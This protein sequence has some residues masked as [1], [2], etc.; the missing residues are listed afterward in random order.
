[1]RPG[2]AAEGRGAP[3]AGPWAWVT[4]LPQGKA[5]GRLERSA[6]PHSAAARRRGSGRPSGQATAGRGGREKGRTEPVYVAVK[7]GGKAKAVK[8]FQK[9][10]LAFPSHPALTWVAPGR[11]G[12]GLGVGRLRP[13]GAFT[14]VG[15]APELF[16]G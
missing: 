14:A 9:R 11:A 7:Y 16:A 13:E 8:T 5:A 15:M 4:P 10:S 3:G 12:A 6:G 1:M 2:R